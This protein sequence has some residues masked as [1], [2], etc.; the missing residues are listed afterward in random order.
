MPCAFDSEKDAT[1]DKTSNPFDTVKLT[2]YESVSLDDKT[3][4]DQC[5]DQEPDN[6]LSCGNNG[7]SKLPRGNARTPMPLE[8]EVDLLSNSPAP[9]MCDGFPIDHL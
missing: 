9:L 5:S 6:P 4:I 3:W 8:A 2:W 7:P 1:S